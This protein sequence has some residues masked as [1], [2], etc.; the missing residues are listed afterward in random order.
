M[1][2]VLLYDYPGSICSQM[3]RLAL[4]E[5]GVTYARQTIDIM[6]THEQF[7]PWY[8]A[9]NAKAVVPTLRIGDEIIT[10][11]INIVHR[12]DAAFDGPALTAPDAPR[13]Q[14]L[15]ARIMG[16]HYGVLLYCDGLTRERTSP[17]IVARGEL[18]AT[19]LKQHPEHAE[20]LKSRIEGNRR[21]Q[22]ILKD[23]QK[24]EAHLQS[25]R[26]LVD[27]LETALAHSDFVAGDSYSLA[28]CF[29]TAALAR[30]HKHGFDI[31]W[32]DGLKPNIHRY[33]MAMKARPSWSAA[34]V[35]EG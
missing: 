22:A 9:L 8:V 31:W 35:V 19:Q 28:D 10:D 7:E 5:K 26:D 30:F 20:L 4:A 27:T 11:T 13:M 17:T 32:E 14:D 3:A 15:M 16:L 6:K 25:T 34:G 2:D 23:A 21:F 24:V 12:V 29:A 1:A 18:L 33:Y